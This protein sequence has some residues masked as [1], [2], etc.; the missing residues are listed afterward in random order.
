[1]NKFWLASSFFLVLL[2]SRTIGS[3]PGQETGPKP[4]DSPGLKEKASLAVNL[5]RAINTAEGSYKVAHGV[6]TS[7]GA[8]AASS[9]FAAARKWAATND[10]QIANLALSKGADILP[11]WSVRLTVGE[12]GRSFDVLL[13]DKGDQAC[14]YAVLS[15][16]RNLIRQSK[17]IDCPI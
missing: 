7:W 2:V 15:D 9:E 1:M 11:G 16:E 5:V 13:E 6:Y 4:T 3:L 14:G 17:T 10:P 8:L 12:G